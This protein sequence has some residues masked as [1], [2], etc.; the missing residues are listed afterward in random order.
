MPRSRS[1][2][3]QTREDE[4]AAEEA[5][6]ARKNREEMDRQRGLAAVCRDVV[7]VGN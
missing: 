5:R 6:L 1:G 4:A 7:S 3:A 2:G